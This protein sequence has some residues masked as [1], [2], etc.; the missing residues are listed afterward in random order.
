MQEKQFNRQSF[1][2][3][4]FSPT[5]EY[6]A[7]FIFV[8][9]STTL[10]GELLFSWL[11]DPS[12][13][14]TTSTVRTLA[15]SIFL[16]IIAGYLWY[17]RPK[18]AVPFD[19]NESQKLKLV[20]AVI[21]IPSNTG[22]VG[23]LLRYHRDQLEHIWLVG[24]KSVDENSKKC[25]MEYKDYRAQFHRIVVDEDVATTYQGYKLGIEQALDEVGDRD[26]IAVDITG[27]T[28]PMTSHA[29][30]SAIE[31]GVRVSYVWSN[32]EKIKGDDQIK[33]EGEEFKVV[34]LDLD[35]FPIQLKFTKE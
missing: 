4:A 15:M 19:I 22:I 32:Y 3:V 35:T 18:I 30:L 12:E 10:L 7:T 14:T 1:S 9:L 29:L 34:E 24:D 6:I 28:K 26:D 16:L 33:R 5:R 25:E 2:D 8:L 20:K 17:S 27:G 31:A 13:V 11:D 21:L 23:K